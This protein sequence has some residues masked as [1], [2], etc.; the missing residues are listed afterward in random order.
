MALPN[1]GTAIHPLV[2]GAAMIIIDRVPGAIRSA[3][4]VAA[5]ALGVALFATLCFSEAIADR[6]NAPDA[7]KSIK[8]PDGLQVPGGLAFAEGKGWEDWAVVASHHTDKVVEAIV[9]NPV[10][11]EAFRAGVPANGKPFPDGA[12]LAKIVWS[13]KKSPDSPHDVKV[14]GALAILEFMV[15]DAK[16]FPNSGGWGYAVFKPDAATDTYKPLTPA[17]S[18]PQWNDAKCGAACHTIAQGKDYVFTEYVKR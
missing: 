6:N 1:D 15:K 10:A 9:G 18:P 3:S 4:A 7:V 8:A 12:K 14:P 2:T 5:G 11:M 16:R 17:D 13:S